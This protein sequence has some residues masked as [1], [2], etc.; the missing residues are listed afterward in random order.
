MALLRAYFMAL[1][2]SISLLGLACKECA[3]QWLMFTMDRY[4][5]KQKQ[6][7][8][9]TCVYDSINSVVDSLGAVFPDRTQ[10]NILVRIMLVND[11]SPAVLFIVMAESA[12]QSKFC[13]P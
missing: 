2:Q 11:G 4:K 13:T 8:V 12:L 9:Y 6:K 3:E 5:K 10:L 1:L 7:T